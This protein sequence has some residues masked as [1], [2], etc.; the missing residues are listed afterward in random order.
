MMKKVLGT[1][2]VGIYLVYAMQVLASDL[3]WKTKANMPTGRQGLA[4]AALNGK[5]YAM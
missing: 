5:I 2:G 4:A 1:L 3:E